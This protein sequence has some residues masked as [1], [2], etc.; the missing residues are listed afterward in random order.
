MN[1]PFT[2][3]Q[4]TACDRGKAQEQQELLI[5]ELN[6]RVCNILNL[7]RSLVEQSRHDAV[8]IATFTELIG[9]RIGALAWAHGN[10][11]EKNWGPAPLS[12]MFEDE[13]KA[14]LNQERGRFKLTGR[15][16]LVTPNAYTVVAL[17]IHEMMTNSAKYGSLSE[18][19]GTLDIDLSTA[20]NG[21]LQIAWRERGGPVVAQP[22]RRGFGSSIIERSIP[23][24][25]KGSA[26]VRYEPAGLEADFTVPSRFIGSMSKDPAFE[27]ERLAKMKP[28]SEPIG[29]LPDHVLVVEDSMIIAMN[30]TE[31]LKE[32]GVAS[33]DTT[34][35]VAGALAAIRERKPD[36]AIVDINLGIETSA[37]VSEELA[38]LGVPFVLATGYGETSAQV[39]NSPAATVLCKPYGKAEIKSAILSEKSSAAPIN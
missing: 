21:D 22:T 6:H 23:F 27:F 7:I 9:G 38:R 35:D 2:P 15:D 8:D 19:H 14:Y 18:R 26:D 5:S 1:T 25:L 34:G 10:I 28:H 39:I 13:T 16:V 20:E 37:P 30:T 17:V 24:E 12:K 29:I 3:E 11:T 32:L 33:V 4:L 31:T 36:F